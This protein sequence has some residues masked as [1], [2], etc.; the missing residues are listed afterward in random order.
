MQQKRTLPNFDA[1]LGMALNDPE[2][3]EQLRVDLTNQV[4]DSAPDRIKH[5]LHGLQFEIDAR[6][7]SASTPLSACMKISEMMHESF[8]SLRIVLNNIA[9]EDSPLADFE[10][11]KLTASAQILPFRSKAAQ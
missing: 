7:R 1:L 2:R 10:K 9:S 8:G 11:P 3:L 5:R 4:I 6:R